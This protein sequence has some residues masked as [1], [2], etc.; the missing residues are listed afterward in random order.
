MPSSPNPQR[1]DG[2]PSLPNW[3]CVAAPSDYATITQVENRL[4]SLTDSSGNPVIDAAG[5]GLMPK[6][7]VATFDQVQDGLSNTIMVVESSGKPQIWRRSYSPIG[8]PPAQMVNG[9]GWARAATDFGL[10]GSSLDGTTL[11]GTCAL[12]CTN[13]DNVGGQ[14]FPYQFY[15]A[16]GSGET[17]SFHPGGANIMFG[18]G[19]L[20]YVRQDADIRVFARLV[21]RS[22][23]EIASRDDLD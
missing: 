9:G 5:P 23:G 18:D 17:F 21:T 6:N 22:G 1:L 3:V 7:S 13:G 19:S 14:T 2:D 12:N 11:P 8:A 20:K 15:G 10:D 16:D 4:A